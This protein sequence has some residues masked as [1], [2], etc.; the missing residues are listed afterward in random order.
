VVV[1]GLAVV[2]V[3]GLVV[4]MMIFSVVGA[5]LAVVFSAVGAGCMELVV[6]AFTAAAGQQR[7]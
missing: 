6:A 3:A 1:A 2:V 7:G 5:G 4:T